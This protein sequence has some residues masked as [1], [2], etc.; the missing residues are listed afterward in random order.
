MGNAYNNK[1]AEN[2]SNCTNPVAKIIRGLCQYVFEKRK[3]ISFYDGF[4]SIFFY[5]YELLF[6]DVFFFYHKA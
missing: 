6:Y 3:S 5:A 2:V 4:F 1:V